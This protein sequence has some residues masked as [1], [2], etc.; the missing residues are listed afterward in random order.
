MENK[1][2][3]AGTAKLEVNG[4]KVDLPVYSGTHGPNVIDIR[5]LYAETDHFTLD[6]GFT[7]TGSC[8]SQITFI[9]GDEGILL[10]RGYPIEQL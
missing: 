4:K 7:S 5:K 8:E 9:D 6:P 3:N 10:H 2:K 1:V